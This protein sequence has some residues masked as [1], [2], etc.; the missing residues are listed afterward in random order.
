MYELYNWIMVNITQQHEILMQYLDVYL[1]VVIAL[2]IAV[3]V[4]VSKNN[5]E[6]H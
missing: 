4:I 2:T 5:K 3:C 6:D 1:I